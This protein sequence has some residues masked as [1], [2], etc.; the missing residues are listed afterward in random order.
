M[1]FQ[2]ARQTNI[3][4]LTKKHNPNSFPLHNYKK[5]TFCYQINS[6]FVNFFINLCVRIYIRG[7]LANTDTVFDLPTE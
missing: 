7:R 1:I 2:L 6:I 4:I 5:Q 3:K